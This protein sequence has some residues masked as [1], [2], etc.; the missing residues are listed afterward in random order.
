MAKNEKTSS[1][2]ATLA[3]K[4]LKDPKSLNAKETKTVMA[5]A[6][7]QSA[8]KP[9]PAAKTPVTAAKAP[10]KTVKAPAAAPAKAPA[11]PV[12]AP[13][14]APKAPAKKK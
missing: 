3:A 1:K 10:P 5:A 13:A 4:G 8:D 12:K 9:K 11:K 14:A 6:L 7:T 2:V